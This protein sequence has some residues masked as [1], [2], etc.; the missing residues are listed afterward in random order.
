MRSQQIASIGV[1]QVGILFQKVHPMFQE[2]A[3]P[4]ERLND[5]I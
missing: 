5:W 2:I 4:V 1:S 3:A